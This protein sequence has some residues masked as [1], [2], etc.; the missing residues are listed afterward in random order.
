MIER[1]KRVNEKLKNILTW[2]I[3][4][5]VVA[6]SLFIGVCINALR[7]IPNIKEQQRIVTEQADRT[8]DSSRELVDT[9]GRIVTLVGDLNLKLTGVI[10]ELDEVSSDTGQIIDSIKAGEEQSIELG[11]SISGSI[12]TTEDI[13]GLNNDLE[14]ILADSNRLFKEVE[15]SNDLD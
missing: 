14:N 1:R 2:V 7:D 15:E 13:R 9:V 4:A 5:Y 3:V 11:Q 8:I 12:A 10:T 6:S